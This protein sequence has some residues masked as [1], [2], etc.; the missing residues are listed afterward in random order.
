LFGQEHVDRRETDGEEGHDCQP[1]ASVGETRTRPCLNV[2]ALSCP[3]LAR[4]AGR[5]S[6]HALQMLVLWFKG[7]LVVAACS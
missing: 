4:F 5:S 6:A 3:Q 7:G 2:V 1:N